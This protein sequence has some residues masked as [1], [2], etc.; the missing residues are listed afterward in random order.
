MTLPVSVEDVFAGKTVEGTFL[1]QTACDKCKG[2]GADSP[3]SLISCP[4]CGGNGFNIV[5][6]VNPYGQ[7][8]VN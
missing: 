7:R 5:E 6:G 2:T 8:F 1:R 4:R 3:K